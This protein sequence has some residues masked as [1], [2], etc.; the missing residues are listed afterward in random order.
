M[1]KKI[2][3]WILAIICLSS[4][5]FAGW[6][7]RFNRTDNSTVGNGWVEI[8][9]VDLLNQEMRLNDN[10]G[11]EISSVNS[12]IYGTPIISELRFKFKL[13]ST[14]KRANLALYNMSGF[15][16]DGEAHIIFNDGDVRYYDGSQQI[17]GSYLANTWYELKLVFNLSAQTYD[18]YLDNVSI[19]ND[20]TLLIDFTGGISKILFSTGNTDDSFQYYIDDVILNDGFVPSFELTAKTYYL[21]TTINTFNATING[22]EYTTSSGTINLTSP[23]TGIVN[24]TIK[25]DNHTTRTYLNYNLSTDLEASL[26]RTDQRLSV[27][28][29]KSTGGAISN[30]RIVIPTLSINTTANP[31]TTTIMNV[32]NYS[33]LTRNITINASDL[34]NQYQ[35]YNGIVEINTTNFN[36]IN[37]SL[38]PYQLTLQF[39][40]PNGSDANISGYYTDGTNTTSFVSTNIIHNLIALPEGVIK[41]YING[42]N[43]TFSTYKQFYEYIN[44]ENNTESKNITIMGNPS[45]EFW[46]KVTDTSNRPIKN[47]IVRLSYSLPDINNTHATY[48]FI[49]QRLTDYNGIKNFFIEQNADLLIQVIAEGYSYEY[50]ITKNTEEMNTTETTPYTIILEKATNVV[51]KNMFLS[52]PNRFTNRSQDIDGGIL[53]I[54]KTT[55]VYTTDFRNQNQTITLNNLDL[56]NFV[57]ESGVDFNAT[58]TSDIQLYI[59]GDGTLY[60]NITIDYITRITNITNEP[61]G[62]DTGI[63]KF[64]GWIGLILIAGTIGVLFGMIGEE[65]STKSGK[66]AKNVFMIG[67]ILVPSIIGMGYWIIFIAVLH[68]IMTGV[69]KVYSE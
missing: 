23:I 29:V 61:S 5:A 28:A 17:V 34:N 15:T 8:G 40:H 59:Y 56:G 32:L 14:A 52:I 11:Q 10:G 57:L 46:V 4:I 64:F 30:A 51:N 13:S 63:K 18:L 21:N 7:D 53:A 12:S 38:S 67:C 44:T 43:T 50:N 48:M 24:I 31:Y 55:V 35:D 62:I 25:A 3:I 54:G 66:V 6:E 1:V 36:D 19:H 39:I 47:A 42:F 41:T 37:V 68:Y 27:R 58:G 60:Y 33:T 69:K 22:T 49:G 9:N 45:K 16:T 26:F 20:T 65:N 2:L